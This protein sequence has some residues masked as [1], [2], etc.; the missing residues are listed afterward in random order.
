MIEYG[1]KASVSMLSDFLLKTGFLISGPDKQAQVRTSTLLLIFQGHSKRWANSDGIGLGIER[2]CEKG[3][4]GLRQ[5]EKVFT[6]LMI[7]LPFYKYRL[8]GIP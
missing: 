3:S 5:R 6:R 8:V 1:G 2:I 7:A 4:T